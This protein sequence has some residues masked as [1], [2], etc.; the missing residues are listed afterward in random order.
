[1]GCFGESG[2]VWNARQWVSERWSLDAA[3]IV[4]S[5]TMLNTT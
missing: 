2:G 1:M 5:R 3:A 4:P